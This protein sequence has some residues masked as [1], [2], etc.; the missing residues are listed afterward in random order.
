MKISFHIFSKIFC[1]AKR[2]GK[3]PEGLVAATLELFTK[4]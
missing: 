3:T 1:F 4:P 2:N